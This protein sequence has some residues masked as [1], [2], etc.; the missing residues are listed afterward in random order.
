MPRFWALWLLS[1][2]LRGLGTIWM[3]F[4][5]FAPIALAIDQLRSQDATYNFN[6]I[7]GALAGLTTVSLAVVFLLSLLYGLMIYAAGQFIVLMIQIEANTRRRAAYTVPPD[8]TLAAELKSAAD[9]WSA[10]RP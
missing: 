2:L 5:V 1:V 3:L 6:S 7:T 4:T 8:D 10:R 9:R